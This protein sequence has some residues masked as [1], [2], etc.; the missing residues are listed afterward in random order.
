M[1]LGGNDGSLNLLRWK[2]KVIKVNEDLRN[3]HVST[4][5]PLGKL[6][7]VCVC[8]FIFSFFFPPE[9]GSLA[10]A[11]H[12]PT[13]S[14]KLS[15]YNVV[16]WFVNQYIFTDRSNEYVQLGSGEKNTDIADIGSANIWLLFLWYLLVFVKEVAFDG[17]YWGCAFY[18]SYE[19][20]SASI[21]PS[22]TE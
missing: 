14:G 10:P 13:P 17:G 7:C 8:V 18:V 15:R 12:T 19:R 22:L 2:L 16:S 5:L 11:Q 3:C 6:V 4:A 20:S 9:T 1:H 21:L